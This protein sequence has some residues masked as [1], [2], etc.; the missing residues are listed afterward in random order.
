MFGKKLIEF[1]IDIYGVFQKYNNRKIIFVKKLN[2][3]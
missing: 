3:L 2:S 1:N